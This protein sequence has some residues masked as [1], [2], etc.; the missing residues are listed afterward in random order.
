MQGLARERAMTPAF[1]AL[2]FALAFWQRPGWATTDTKIDLHVDPARFLSD[3]ASTW[4]PTTDLGAVHSAQYSG[5]LWPMGPFYATLRALDLSPWV[6]QR[7]WLGLLLALAAWGMLRL[8]DLLLGRPRGIAHVV[9]AAFFVA[10]PYT[11]FSMAR[12]TS[13]LIGYA[14]LPWLLIVVHQ[15]VRSVRG[16]RGWRGWWWAAAFALI[17]TSTGAGI[18][19]AVVGWMLVGPLLLLLYEPVTGAVRWRDAG[20]F[21][22][23][24]AVLGVLASLWWIVPLLVHVRYGIDFLQFTEQPRS[25]W[26]TNSITETLRL[27]GYWTSYL[28]YGFGAVRPLFDDSPTMLFNPLVVGASLVLPALAAAGFVWTRRFRYGPFLL[29]MLLVGV[30]IMALGY[31]DG[32]PAREAME[33]VYRKAWLV[34]FMRTTQ[35]A[36]PLVAAGVGGLLGLAAQVAWARLRALPAGRRRSAALVAAPATLAALIVLAALPLFRGEALDAQLNWKRIPAAWTDAGR[37]LDRELPANTRALVLPGSIFAYYR[38]GGT[39]DSIVPRVTERPVAV[40]YETPLSDLHAAD[41]LTTVDS[42][43]QQRR[44]LPGQLPPLLRMMGVGAVVSGSDD[45]LSRSGSLDPA[46]AADELGRQGLRAPSREY[47][48][49]RSFLPARRDF[50]PAVDLPQVRRYDVAGGRGIVHVNPLAPATIV[51]GEAAGLA[52]LAAFGALPERHPIL[53][54]GDLT[55]GELRRE[56][57]RG[58]EVVVTDSNRR[59]S[60]VPSFAHQ[61]VGATLGADDPFDPNAAVLNPFP[62]RG[63]DAQTVSVLQGAAYARAPDPSSSHLFPEH[64]PVA[65]FD[66]DRSTSWIADRLAPREQW[67]LEIAFPRPRNVPYVDVYPVSRNHGV[68][69]A[70]DVNG[71]TRPVGHAWTRIPVRKRDV[72]TL[73]LRIADVDQPERGLGSAGGFREVR[74]PG[75]RVRQF[76]RSPILAGRALAGRDLRRV[77]LTYLFERTTGDGPFQRDRY[78][79]DPSTARVADRGDAERYIDRA[80]FAPDARSYSVDAWV[81][82]ALTAPDSAF[83]RLVGLPG[84]TAFESSS[85]FHDILRYRSSSAFDGRAGT[86]WIGIWARPDAPHPWIAWRSRRPLT[87]ARLRLT[88]ARDPVRRPAAV[89]VSWPGGATPPLHVRRGGSVALPRAVRARHFRLTVLEARFPPGTTRRQRAVRAVGVASLRVPGLRPVAVP[90]SGPLRAACGDVRASVGGRA[91][92]LR[93]AGTIADLDAGRP[94]RARSCAGKVRMG[95]S[96]QRLRSL[97]G[98][99][100]VDALRLRSAARSPAASSGGGR[101]VEAGR[102]GRSSVDGVRVA[103]RGASW[104]VL[105]ESF[106]RGW[107]AECD[108]RSLGAPRVVDGYANG[109]LAPPSCRA[110]SFSFAPQAD[111]RRSYVVSAVVC[112]LLAAFLV[113]GRFALPWQRVE[114][115]RAPLPEPPPRPM[116]LARALVVA[117]ALTVPL[118]LAFALRTSLGIAPILAFVLWRGVSPRA[119]T[120]AGAVLLGVVVPVLYAGIGPTNQ[121]GYSSGYANSLISAHWAGLAAVLLLALACWRTLAATHGRRPEPARPPPPDAE[122]GRS[123]RD[124]ELAGRPARAD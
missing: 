106:N 95:G 121:G 10:N 116:P 120:V 76:L 29:A 117:A 77:G 78:T 42:L 34:R 14:A 59:R 8:L 73:R 67:W 123:R 13:A 33:W 84:G 27:M 48:P 119:L 20:G 26:G 109:W 61:N 52:N 100:S 53:Y 105:G 1:A 57:A 44:L 21:L 112:A 5:Y 91:V 17:L 12:S 62:E 101:V 90:R 56:A 104:L 40:R 49:M 102:I 47:G 97:P 75:V 72:S 25:I 18:N 71:V 96:I 115:S 65:A 51:D 82:P 111:A 54:A 83:D 93:P 103:L 81:N 99:F 74:V 38:W 64:A 41:L 2:A 66:G 31:P 3:V 69:K 98:A 94:L 92:P 19:A 37:G 60:F 107:R 114:P 16:L 68:V 6:I 45:D 32:T 88:P 23:R 122:R 110:A 124:L 85:R 50:G 108:G 58:A 55:S 9:A 63:S 89:R 15:G 24:M 87:V 43:V 35:K 118:S 28:G 22:L 113:M 70:V 36:A 79:A 39:V 30:V 11:V 46:A 80:I 4:T 7:L 86:A